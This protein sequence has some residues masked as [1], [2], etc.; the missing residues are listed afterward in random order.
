LRRSGRRVGGADEDLLERIYTLRKE[1]NEKRKKIEEL[2]IGLKYS[3]DAL[4]G[5]QFNL[6]S[7]KQQLERAEEANRNLKQN[8]E[9][10]KNQLNELKVTNDKI[11][12][13]MMEMKEKIS[14]QMA[15]IERVGGEVKKLEKEL[16]LE[17]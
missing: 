16:D 4:N 14:E 13:E 8:E 3:T 10:K 12:A 5:K 6:K 11:M 17:K 9:D 1:N 7:E 15:K 2:T